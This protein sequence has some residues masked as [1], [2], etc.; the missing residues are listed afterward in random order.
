MKW[1]GGP[2]PVMGIPAGSVPSVFWQAASPSPPSCSGQLTP[3]TTTPVLCSLPAHPAARSH[4]SAKTSEC[5]EKGSLS[6]S[7]SGESWR[8]ISGARW[9]NQPFWI[10]SLF[11]R[12]P[13]HGAKP[14]GTTEGNITTGEQPHS[15]PTLSPGHLSLV[16]CT[17]SLQSQVLTLL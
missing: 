14:V 13:K 11:S 12:L 1:E 9:H 17:A 8:M 3:D 16:F 10:R 2:S 4:P 6:S 5:L 15:P 7:V